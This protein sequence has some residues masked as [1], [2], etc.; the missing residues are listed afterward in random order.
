MRDIIAIERTKYKE[1]GWFKPVAISARI[2]KRVNPTIERRH[3]KTLL[4]KTEGVSA[5][6]RRGDEKVRLR[7][8]AVSTNLPMMTDGSGGQEHRKGWG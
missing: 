8:G 5:V 3:R 2:L 4:R 7:I 6:S 1:I